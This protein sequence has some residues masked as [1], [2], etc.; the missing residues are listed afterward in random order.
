MIRALLGEGASATSN[1]SFLRCFYGASQRSSFSTEAKA[2]EKEAAN[3]EKEVGEGEKSS[4]RR[5]KKFNNKR[6]EGFM[7]QPIEYEVVHSLND[8][9]FEVIYN[10]TIKNLDKDPEVLKNLPKNLRETAAK[11]NLTVAETL[12]VAKLKLLEQEFTAEDLDKYQTQEMRDAKGVA[13][14]PVIKGVESAVQ[15]ERKKYLLVDPNA[16]EDEIDLLAHSSGHTRLIEKGGGVIEVL[17]VTPSSNEPTA[18]PTFV[19]AGGQIKDDPTE[20]KKASGGR[21]YKTVF[22]HVGGDGPGKT[23]AKKF[24]DRPILIREKDGSA[25][26]PSEAERYRLERKFSPKYFK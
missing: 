20:Y 17:E 22:A 15:S 18:P 2:D 6:K 4:S 7:R 19:A 12:G 23:D 16:K 9:T 24:L 3:E 26:G 8:A 10:N 13:V 21:R 5:D 14:V 11:F 1:G 25:R